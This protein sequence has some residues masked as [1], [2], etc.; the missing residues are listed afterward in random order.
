MS[1]ISV[2]QSV[3]PAEAMRAGLAVLLSVRVFDKFLR[4]Y[5]CD[6]RELQAA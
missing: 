3:K 4:A 5:H 2:L 6:V 1:L